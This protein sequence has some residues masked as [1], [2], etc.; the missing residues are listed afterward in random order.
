MAS[1]MGMGPG[2][3]GTGKLDTQDESLFPDLA[4]ADAIIEQ[5]K[6]QQPAFK[7]PKK[8]PVGGGATWGSKLKKANEARKAQQNGS[9][10]ESSTQDEPK[11]VESTKDEPPATEA[12]P[13]PAPSNEPSKETAPAPVAKAPIK[14]KKKKKKDLST[15][16]PSS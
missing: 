10:Q 11:P 12:A 7:I 6:S 14:P 9:A 3:S 4:S 15:F 16:K 5:Q 8:T 1:R 2:P 13:A